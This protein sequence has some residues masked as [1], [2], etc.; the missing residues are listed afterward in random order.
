MRSTIK[1]KYNENGFTLL[2]LALVLVIIGLIIAPATALYKNY[3]IDKDWTETEENIDTIQVE[4]GGYRDNFRRYPCPASST[5]VP[6]DAA[7]GHESCTPGVA[8]SCVDGIC[9]YASAIPGQTV[10]VGSLPFKTLNL[11]ESEVYDRYLNKVTYAVTTDL[12]VPATFNMSGGGIGIVDPNGNSV[13]TPSDTGHFVIISHGPNKAGGSTRSGLVGIPCGSGSATEQENCDGNATFLSSEARND[14]DDRINF[15]SSVQP[16]EWQVSE[17]DDTAIHL[18]TLDSIAI[19]PTAD[20]LTT[21]EQTTVRDFGVG[22]SGTVHADGAFFVEN[23][24]EYDGT[25]NADCF[26]P[27][28]IAGSLAHDGNR[29]HE[30]GSGNGMSCYDPGVQDEFLVGIE[31]GG[32]ICN[33][34]IFISCPADSFIEG[35]DGDGTVMCDSAP[36]PPCTGTGVTTTCG[37]SRSIPATFSGGYE[38]VYSGE[39][40]TM[41]DYDDAYFTTALSGM[42]AGQIGAHINSL[43][44]ETR[45][46]ED[47]GPNSSGSQ[48]RDSYLC[49]SGSW[50]LATTHERRYP[51]YSFPS[52]SYNGGSWPAETSYNGA[53]ASNSNHYH[54]CWCREDYRVYADSYC[55]GGLT[56]TRIRIQKHTCPQTQH[57]WSTVHT[58]YDLCGCSPSQTVELQSCNSYYDE[59]N[60]TSGTSGLTGSVALTY[61]ITC[62]SDT[63]VQ[64]AVPSNIDTAGCA[65]PANSPVI[66]RTYCATGTT[67][68]WSWAGGSEVGVESLSIT[69]WTCPGT[70]TGG[71]PDPGA[72]DSTIDYSPI[73]AC[74]CD[75]SLTDTV[76]EACPAGLDGTITY[77]RDW[78]CSISNWEVRDDWDVISND[79]KSC[80]WTA[81]SGSPSLEDF[82]YGEEKG[83]T[84]ACG[85]AP[86]AFCH[87]YASG[88]KYNVWTGCQCEVQDD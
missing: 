66:G 86:A 55:P 16:S 87:D 77:E 59:V 37:D 42:N 69:N 1:T 43:N 13:I 85:D 17:A 56:G 15:F 63:P 32:P 39:C 88:G 78:D 36:P 41:T 83:A 71:L 29:F 61:D 52:Q 79:C 80:S 53:D 44:A 40:R 45:T 5:A 18:K 50:S 9:T 31:N 30:D 28:R 57:Y 34:E 68:S 62:V 82:A 67:N 10:L 27:R 19:A 24:C 23:L 7:Y 65:C 81:P 84:C 75:T 74:T 33:D 47:C 4:L 38:S 70:T 35:I 21:A 20:N 14:F 60:G 8:G 76:V 25:T 64:S 22:D 2:E 26:A 3:R 6:G 12:T 11:Q 49:T 48:V 58:S 73:P 51:W 54:D 46:I 72:W